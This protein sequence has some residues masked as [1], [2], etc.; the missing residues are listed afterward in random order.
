[1]A[2]IATYIEDNSGKP[3][4]KPEDAVLSDIAL[5]LGKIGDADHDMSMGIA[6]KI[7]AQREVIAAAF[8][9]FDELTAPI[10]HAA[11]PDMPR[12]GR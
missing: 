3:H 9:D 1:M 5:A 8:K 11:E 6:R 7:L 12:D 2:K 10:A 4:K